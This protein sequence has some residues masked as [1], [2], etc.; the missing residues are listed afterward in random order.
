MVFCFYKHHTRNKM[1]DIKSVI[2]NVAEDFFGKEGKYIAEAALYIIDI[3]KSAKKARR[4]GS[5]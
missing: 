2:P 3:T 4:D 5:L 1:S